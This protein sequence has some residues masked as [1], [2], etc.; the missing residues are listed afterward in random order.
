MARLTSTLRSRVAAHRVADGI[1]QQQLAAAAE[2]SRQTIISIERGDYAPSVILALR[3]S[4]L[5]GVPVEQLFSLP[6]SEV[7]AL[8]RWRERFSSETKKEGSE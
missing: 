7:E 3:L 8:A 5:L 2:V 1:T 6:D 4:L